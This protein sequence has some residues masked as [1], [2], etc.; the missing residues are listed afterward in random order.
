MSVSSI[1]SN[2]SSPQTAPIAHHHHKRAASVKTNG[3]SQASQIPATSDNSNGSAS[4][5]GV[6]GAS[7]RIDIHA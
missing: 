2:T 6:S 4:Y 7:G 5:H 3:T 1:T